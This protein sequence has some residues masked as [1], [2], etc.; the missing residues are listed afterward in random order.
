MIRAGSHQNPPP[1]RAYPFL[2]KLGGFVLAM[3]AW[4][5]S[6][7][8]EKAEDDSKE[9]PDRSDGI[10][11]AASAAERLGDSFSVRGDVPDWFFSTRE[12]R[13]VALGPFW[14][15]PWSEVARNGTDPA[16][17]LVEMNQLLEAK[18][19]AL[20]L[21]LV[22]T[23]AGLHPEKLDENFSAGEALMPRPLL[24]RIQESGIELIDLHERFVSQRAEDPEMEWHCASDS[25][26]S[27]RAV[28]FIADAVFEAA[29]IQ[30]EEDPGIELAE[31]RRVSFRGDLVV[32]SE[33]ED[34]V[35][36]EML[37]VR[38]VTE[39]GDV[40]VT[41]DPESPFL[42]LGD[43]HT[44]VFHEGAETGMITRGAGLMEHL[45]QR[46]GRAFDLVGVRGSGIVQARKKL[47]FHASERPDYWEG[48]RL[49]VWV[50]SE[51]E[52]T[53]SSDRIVSIPLER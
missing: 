48:K 10:S 49:V 3:M 15:K 23:K 53:Q 32:G 40:G 38:E 8:G 12:L 45:S 30:R 37:R 6:A 19:V 46:F 28:E 27:P 50:F 36:P 7:Q 22:P 4:S 21:V 26:F 18:G 31:P 51:R 14:E 35:A 41:P 29:G 52:L 9:A 16:P 47:F 39:G 20:F 34:E 24:R 17:A 42:L 2:W 5:A 43:S 13:H 11:F 33:W 25:H 1:L 44:L